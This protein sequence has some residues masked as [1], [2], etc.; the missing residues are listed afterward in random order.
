MALKQRLLYLSAQTTDPKSQVISQA[1]HEPIND[2]IVEIDPIS[3]KIDYESVHEAICDGWRVI[4]FPNQSEVS[5][6]SYDII[7][8]Q[9]VLE[10]IEDFDD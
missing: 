7:G 8:F 2:N 10:Q 4:H 1:L 5:S 9:F 3:C 6:E